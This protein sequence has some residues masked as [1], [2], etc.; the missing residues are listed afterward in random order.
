MDG[1]G[2]GGGEDVHVYDVCMYVCMYDGDPQVGTMSKCN[3]QDIF[4]SFFPYPS[5]PSHSKLPLQT[6]IFQSLCLK[7]S[8]FHVD[9]TQSHTFVEARYEKNTAL[10]KMERS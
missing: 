8:V 3:A 10:W 1:E 5:P 9:T 6:Y 2:E 7:L 4:F